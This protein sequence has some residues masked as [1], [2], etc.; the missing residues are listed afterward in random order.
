MQKKVMIIDDDK[1]F[2][3]EASETL[4]LAGYDVVVVNDAETAA[5]MV[6]RAKPDV[7]LLDIRMPG[8]SGYEVASE[9]TSLA[10]HNNA[11]IGM[12]GFYRDKDLMLM[13]ICGIGK[14]LRKPLFPLNMIYHIE[15]A[16][17]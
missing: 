10:G 16:I 13:N 9:I 14:C 6:G 17:K 1:G 12:T 15:A 2:L 4:I 11:I 8:R 3:D 7:I 5:D